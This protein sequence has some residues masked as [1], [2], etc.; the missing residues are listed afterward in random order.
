[1]DNQTTTSCKSSNPGYPD[2]DKKILKIPT[3][4]KQQHPEN[5][6]ILEILIQTN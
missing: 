5:P 2:S 1:M 3:A 6:L 4:N